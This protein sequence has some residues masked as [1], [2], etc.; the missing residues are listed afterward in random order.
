[1]RLRDPKE[2]QRERD[3]KRDKDRD[4][5]GGKERKEI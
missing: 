1:M 2:R 4:T 3:N 5:N